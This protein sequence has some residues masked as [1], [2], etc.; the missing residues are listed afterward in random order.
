M[1]PTLSTTDDSSPSSI[2]CFYSNNPFTHLDIP[3]EPHHRF[4]FPYNLRNHD[5]IEQLYPI[6]TYPND[7]RF[8]YGM[9]DVQDYRAQAKKVA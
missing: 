2:R 7:C 9:E 6:P 4:S 1:S 3:L 5:T 8:R